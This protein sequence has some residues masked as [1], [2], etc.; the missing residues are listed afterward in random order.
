VR[1]ASEEVSA[2]IARGETVAPSEYYLRTTPLFE[3][4]DP[5]YAWLNTIVCVG[6]GE[7]LPD[8]AKYDVFEVL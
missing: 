1:H 2:R 3:T 8:A 4:S 5:R 7:R 6:V